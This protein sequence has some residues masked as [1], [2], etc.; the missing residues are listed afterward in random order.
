MYS[1]PNSPSIYPLGER[2][3]QLPACA[4]CSIQNTAIFSRPI[5]ESTPFEPGWYN[6]HIP[7]SHTPHCDTL[8]ITI[9][10]VAWLHL[11]SAY[12]IGEEPVMVI[13]MTIVVGGTSRGSSRS[14]VLMHEVS[15]SKWG[16]RTV[17]TF[18]FG[19]ELYFFALSYSLRSPQ[20]TV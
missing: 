7:R 13:W 2:G 15:A 14:H 10:Y 3:Y 16:Y 20:Q 11:F 5:H 17:V 12:E 18:S 6:C 4:H 9:I 1:I 19:T 8:F